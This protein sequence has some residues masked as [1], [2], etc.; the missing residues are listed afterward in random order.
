MALDSPSPS[1][2]ARIQES[3]PCKLKRKT[4][5][6]FVTASPLKRTPKTARVQK[7]LVTLSPRKKSLKTALGS[8]ARNT[9]VTP[10]YETDGRALDVV[11]FWVVLLAVL[12]LLCRILNSLLLVQLLFFERPAHRHT[13]REP[14]I[15]YWSNSTVLPFT[16][17]IVFQLNPIYTFNCYWSKSRGKR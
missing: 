10:S 5:P 1:K 12:I 9:S 13:Q 14:H 6:S 16:V 4:G 8:G 7:S 15:R 3:S 17:K 11:S 2:K